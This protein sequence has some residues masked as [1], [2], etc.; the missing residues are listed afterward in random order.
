MSLWCGMVRKEYNLYKEGRAHEI[1]GW[2]VNLN[3]E[4]SSLHMKHI[5]EGQKKAVEIIIKLN[6]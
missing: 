1:S 5:E 2:R 3:I 6:L 4:N